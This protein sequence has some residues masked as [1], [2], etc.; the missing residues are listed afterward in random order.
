MSTTL[1]SPR[2][3]RDPVQTWRLEQL[4]AAGYPHAAAVLISERLD[5]DLHLAVRL[6]EQGCPP[7]TALRILV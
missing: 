4:E 7:E 1:T 2:Q 5:V 6:V 3:P